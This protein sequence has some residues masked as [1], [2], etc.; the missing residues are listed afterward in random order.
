MSRILRIV[1]A[2]NL[3]AI[4]ILAFVYPNL[5]VGPGKL[6]SG[7]RQLE[8]DCFACHAPL[9]GADSKRCVSCHKPADVGR[10]TTT[11]LPVLKPL[12]STPFHQRL[13]S[14]DCVACHSDHAGVKR[15]R[16]QGR[17]NHALLQKDTLDQ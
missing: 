2:A 1:L 7:H 10:L 4:A 8:S 16:Q 15:Y 6:I 11:G 17:F 3:I 13:A 12:S 14:Q 9:L 5:M